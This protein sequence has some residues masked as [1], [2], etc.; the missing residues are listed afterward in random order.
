MHGEDVVGRHGVV[1]A[2]VGVPPP[3]PDGDGP[4]EARGVLVQ[5]REDGEGGV[6]AGVLVD[7]EGAG[8]QQGPGGG[9]GGEGLGVKLE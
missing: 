3:V 4:E 2:P 7:H 6:P 1:D 8:V 5:G 9:V